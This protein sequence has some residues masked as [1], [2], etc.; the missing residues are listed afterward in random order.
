MYECLKQNRDGQNEHG[1][2][3]CTR[4]MVEKN[5]ISSA[6]ICCLGEL[7]HSFHRSQ[8]YSTEKLTI[9]SEMLKKNKHV[10][11]LKVEREEIPEP[12]NRM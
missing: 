5:T 4:M 7:Y 8:S 2:W 12:V 1:H 3:V 6:Y 11:V 9:A 10:H